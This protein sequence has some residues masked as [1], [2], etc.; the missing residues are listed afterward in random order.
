MH[1]RTNGVYMNDCVEISTVRH[2][3]V[4]ARTENPT[5]ASLD[6]CDKQ[7]RGQPCTAT[8]EPDPN[9]VDEV[10]LEN[11]R[12]TREELCYEMWHITGGSTG[13]NRRS[14]IGKTLCTVGAVNANF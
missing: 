11:Y 3:A 12:I 8:N 7:R 1:L 9:L 13:Y 4:C 2:W 14:E 10:I 6:L 5:V